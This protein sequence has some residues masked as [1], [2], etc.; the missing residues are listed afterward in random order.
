MIL[1][2]RD[3]AG[4]GEVCRSE[5]VPRWFASAVVK[6]LAEAERVEQQLARGEPAKIILNV[7]GTSVKGEITTFF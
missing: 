2:L 3:E 7:K 1:I 6:L 4:A 5:R